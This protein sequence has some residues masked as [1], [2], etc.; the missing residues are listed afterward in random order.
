MNDVRW[1]RGGCRGGGAQ[2]PKQ[3]TGPSVRV[4]HHVFGLQTLAWWKL[5]VLTGKKLALKFSAYVFEYRPLPPYVHLM[6]THVMNAPRPS[7]SSAPMYYC[8][9]KRKVKTGEGWERGYFHPSQ[10][11][12]LIFSTFWGSCYKRWPSL[13]A[14]IACGMETGI[15]RSLKEALKSLLQ[16]YI[17]CVSNY[18]QFRLAL[19]SRAY[20]RQ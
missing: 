19:F 2:L 20:T 11:I 6:S 7:Q 18:I 3:R 8:E 14:F 4:L 1:T 15:T 17:N 9:R 10:F 5:L 16:A 13:L 12:W